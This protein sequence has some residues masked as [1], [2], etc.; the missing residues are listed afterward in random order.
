[1]GSFVAE[2]MHI[3]EASNHVRRGPAAR[4]DD[5]LRVAEGRE[6]LPQPVA[7]AGQVEET[8]ADLDDARDTHGNDGQD[9]TIGAPVKATQDPSCA[10]RTRVFPSPVHEKR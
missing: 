9:V 3:I 5:G 8:A 6:P 2:L 1:M 7:Q 4:N 10:K